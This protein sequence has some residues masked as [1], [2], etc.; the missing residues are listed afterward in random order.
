M[1]VSRRVQTLLFTDIVGST[2]RLR[3]LG[4]A[5]WAALLVRHHGVV[6]SALA[7]HGGREVDTAGDG[8]LAR[9]DAP[10]SA[11]RAAVAAV[12]AM[13]PLRMEIRAGL[14]TGEVELDGDVMTGVGVHLAAR[15]M[16]E[17]APGQVLVS[18]TVRELM[19]GSGLGFV[20]LGVRELK[21]FAERWRLFALDPA[22]V[23]G[24]DGTTQLPWKPTAEVE[25][26]GRTGVP[27]P[28][29]LSVGRST[30][31]VGRE[32]LLGRLEQA[33]RQT[34][35]GRCR[36]VRRASGD[37]LTRALQLLDQVRQGAVAIQAPNL[38]AQAD[39]LAARPGH[40]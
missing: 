32:E 30:G 7:A 9:F 38:V 25:G 37:H 10:A 19:A 29:L 2:D 34:T 35:A 15:V 1:A 39:E 24:D 3:D 33:H 26:Q 28:G 18:A 27:F 8:F 14:H 16:G 6:R 13:A 4:D 23:Q 21:G 22:T 31:Y 40:L 12:A 17:A 11:L 20:D 36:A 5:A